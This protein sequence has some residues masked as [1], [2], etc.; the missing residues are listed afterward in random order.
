MSKRHTTL[1]EMTDRLYKNE[2]KVGLK[3]SC[4]KNKRNNVAWSPTRNTLLTVEGNQI[5]HIEASACQGSNLSN[6]D[7]IDSDIN[8]VFCRL[9]QIW[10]RRSIDKSSVFVITTALCASET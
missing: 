2:A 9:D 8:T 10:K 6:N 1:Q 7:N 5:E 4:E 3:I